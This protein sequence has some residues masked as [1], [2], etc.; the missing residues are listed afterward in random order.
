MPGFRA[1]SH[2]STAGSPAPAARGRF[3]GRGFIDR[4]TIQPT[5]SA[6][7]FAAIVKL[8]GVAGSPAVRI[9]LVWMG[10]RRVPGIVAGVELAFEGMA[11][12]VDG[13]PTIYNPR[14]EIIGR[15][16]EH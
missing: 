1:A 11:S 5:T 6:P 3:G 16:E 12:Q 13:V 9:R 15:P 14:Y 4:V 7:Q 2:R 8:S 10:Q